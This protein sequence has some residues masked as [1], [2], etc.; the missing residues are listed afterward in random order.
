[1]GHEQHRL[2]Q[3]PLEQ[4]E[5]ALQLETGQGVERSER[6]VQQHDVGIGRQ[7]AGEGDALALPAGQ[8]VG[9]TR[10]VTLRLQADEAQQFVRPIAPLP[11]A[12]TEQSR[13]QADV[14]RDIPVG[15]QPPLLLHVS[16]MAAQPD[17]VE[18]GG[19]P[20]GDADL[21]ARGLFQ[22]VEHAQQRGLPTTALTDQ[23]HGLAPGHDQ[24]DSA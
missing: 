20:A 6:L 17:R 24:I 11:R 15:Q 18:R 3:L 7:R 21:S 2:G 14:A 16:G 13:H 19:R 8:L 23:R 5:L 9:I 10:A 22:A 1:M 12:P 4:Q